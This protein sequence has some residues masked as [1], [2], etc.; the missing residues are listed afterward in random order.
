[1]VNPYSWEYIISHPLFLTSYD[2]FRYSTLILLYVQ[3][4]NLS[5]SLLNELSVKYGIQTHLSHAPL[6][7]KLEELREYIR[8]EIKK[9]L[10]V[11]ILISTYL[12]N[13]TEHLCF[14][15]I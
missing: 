15:I 3:D 9:E 1:M 13:S 12:T 2:L 14:R 5:L 8:R 10:K 6:P 11:R 7:Q 4:D